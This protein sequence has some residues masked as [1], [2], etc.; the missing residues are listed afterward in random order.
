[1]A[2]LSGL[3]GDST[4]RFLKEAQ[5][6]VDAVNKLE[7]TFESFSLEQIQAKS[8]ELK[9]KIQK[10]GLTL[11]EILPE[12]FA[13][14]REASRR[15]LGQ[16]HFDV[17]IIGS[18]VLNAGS[19]AEMKT[20]E[21]KTLA[22]TMAVYL[23]ALSGQGVHVVTVNDFLARRDTA[24]MGEIY[25]ILGLSIAC[26]NQQASFIYDPNFKEGQEALDRERDELG[27]FRIVQEF[28]RP[29]SRREAYEA[30]IT[31]G[32]KN[33]FGF[34]YLRDNMAY[35]LSQRVQ[36]KGHNFAIVDEVDS[37]LIDESRTPL[38]I[39][40]AE[41]DSGNLYAQFAGIVPR[42]KEDED[43]NVD[44]KLKA[45]TI[46][47]VGIE[48]IEKILNIENIYT[49]TG[50][51]YVHHLEQALRAQVLFEK[52]KHYVVRDGKVIIV[53]E[54][55]G[56]LMPGRRWSG[57]LH[58]AVEAK[59]GVTIEKESRTMATITFQNYFRLY[60]KLSG[61][62]GTGATSEEEFRTVYGMTVI[63]VPTNRPLL[64]LDQPDRIYKTETGKF[65]ALVS[66]I[67]DRHKNGQPVL[68]GTASIQKN[69]LVGNLLGKAGISM[70]F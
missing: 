63:K 21:G 2:F 39:S 6:I 20:G 67:Q 55:T 48:K 65:R 12:A 51:R 58:Q 69:E 42:L 18:L 70:R 44:E 45:V 37:I 22:A 31:Y 29:V 27:N 62:T 30:D 49:E 8:T 56:R 54:F 41:E 1:M 7:P 53:D 33:E 24:W 16:R 9:N 34:D 10:E 13:L 11:E 23:N 40:A 61:M 32:T 25:D 15:T 17:Q 28:L 38:I 14:V 43:Y 60:K 68:V 52:D 59:E 4:N 50:V 57:G 5:K 46:T 64:R 35:D 36:A 66:E 3:F 26:I 47:E 19:V